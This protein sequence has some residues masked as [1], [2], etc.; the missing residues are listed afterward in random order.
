M[1]IHQY[2]FLLKSRKMP[3]L[4]N[5]KKAVFS[6]P[7]GPNQYFQDNKI[8]VSV[9]NGFSD[10][11]CHHFLLLK[12]SNH[13]P[14]KF[15]QIKRLSIILFLRSSHSESRNTHRREPPAKSSTFLFSFISPNVTEQESSHSNESK[16]PQLNRHQS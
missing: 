5:Y 1:H 12:A 15:R 16:N 13:H 14:S 6:I 4:A 8:S 7:G 10:K 3:L 11:K 9:F 2:H